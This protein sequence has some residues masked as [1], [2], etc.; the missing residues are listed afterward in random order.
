[1]GEVFGNSPP[2]QAEANAGPTP[3]Y[4]GQLMAAQGYAV[5]YASTPL[6][7]GATT[8]MTATLAAQTVAAI[9]AAAALGYVDPARVGVIGHSFGGYSVAA[10]L[11]HRSDRFR[12]GI[13]MDGLYDMSDNWGQR[14]LASLLGDH[15]GQDFSLET[16]LMAEGAQSGLGAPFW[17]ATEAYRRNSPIYRADKIDAPI[18][19]L[20]GDLNLGA[21]SLVG[22]E[23]FYAAL[24]RE[25]K[26]PVLVRYWGESHVANDAGALRDQWRRITAW[27]AHYLKR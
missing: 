18:L 4:N 10:I 21:T 26:H 8:D 15:A 27:F 7:R 6:G 16:K 14:M 5:L 19:L 20:H 11:S 13:A 9:D 24:R 23:R 17:R 1:G 3:I 12:A 2:R 25:G 22:A